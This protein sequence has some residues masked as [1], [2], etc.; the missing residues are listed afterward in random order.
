MDVVQRLARRAD[1]DD[2]RLLAV[3]VRQQRDEARHVQQHH[4]CHGAVHVRAQRV[5]RRGGLLA[6]NQLE[7][8]LEP[9]AAREVAGRPARQVRSRR[10]RLAR[11]H[12]QLLVVVLHVQRRLLP[13]HVVVLGRLRARGQRGQQAATGAPGLRL[14]HLL[15]G[16]PAVARVALV[17]RRATVALVVALQPLLGGQDAVLGGLAL[18][19][20][21]TLHRNSVRSVQVARLEPLGPGL[22]VITVL[23]A[24]ADVA[25]LVTHAMRRLVR[26]VQVV[27]R[28]IA[29]HGHRVRVGFAYVTPPG[30]LARHGIRVHRAVIRHVGRIGAGALR[31]ARLLQG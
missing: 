11:V 31:H 4:G 12:H 16:Q 19:A 26:R 10:V 8:P 18:L 29:R 9:L 1:V 28:V 30:V 24:L 14:A 7:Q 25:Q 20:T 2:V 13:V 22:V 3:D 23:V 6:R 17:T 5:Q 21:Q 15:G 27:V